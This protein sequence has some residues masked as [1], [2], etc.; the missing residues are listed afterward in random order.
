MTVGIEMANMLPVNYGVGQ[1]AFMLSDMNGQILTTQSSGPLAL[2]GSDNGG[3]QNGLQNFNFP[4]Q[5]PLG[6]LNPITLVSRVQQ[7]MNANVAAFTGDLQITNPQAGPV[8]V[9]DLK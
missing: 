5:I 6:V 8:P 9:S 3:A 1:F 4:T 7:L 2:M